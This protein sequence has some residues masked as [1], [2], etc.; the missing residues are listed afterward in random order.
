MSI[1]KPQQVALKID[2]G[3][4]D[5]G[6]TGEQIRVAKFADKMSYRFMPEQAEGE[7]HDQGTIR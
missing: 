1:D 2:C 7:S 5:G 6:V 3:Q 4:V